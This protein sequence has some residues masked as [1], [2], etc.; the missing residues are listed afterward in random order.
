MEG[1]F[2]AGESGTIGIVL[3]YY[4]RSR[5]KK[6]TELAQLRSLWD[7][8]FNDPPEF[9]EYYYRDVCAGNKMLGAYTGKELVGMIHLNPYRVCMGDF[10]ADS[11]YIVGVAVKERLQRRGIMRLMMHRV[12]SDMS[13]WGCPF[14]FLMPKKREYYAGFGFE[15][16]YETCI[17]QFGV[18]DDSDG[19]AV[20]L[21]TEP[22]EEK[23]AN[24]IDMDTLSP[25][26]LERLAEYINQKLSEQ[27]RYF[28][29]RS[30]GYLRNMCREHRCQ[31]GGVALADRG[32][33]LC[34]F[35][36]D[37]YEN[38]MY[39]ERFELLVYPVTTGMLCRFVKDILAFAKT[40]HC[41]SCHMTVP[42]HIAAMFDMAEVSNAAGI[43][44]SNAGEETPH[45][46]AGH[47]I[48]ALSLSERTFSVDKMKKTSFFDEIV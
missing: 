11:Y 44:N 19:G 41:R 46:S 4:E 37:I 13:E 7:E 15:P 26:Q 33:D 22:E 28:S 34:L 32:R 8:A 31:H 45:V 40:Q 42:A 30:A 38:V 29:K 12:L 10:E 39:V 3:R 47:G 6:G 48:M 35:S 9:A 2:M 25:G 27:Y 1:G 5:D 16:V 24:I 17:M 43:S 14:T 36:Y 20:R 18:D 21:R 23:R